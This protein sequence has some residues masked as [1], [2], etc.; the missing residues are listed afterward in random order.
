MLALQLAM[1][2]SP[3]WLRA[4]AVAP[5]AATIGVERG[6]QFAVAN[7]LKRGPAEPGGVKALERLAHRRRRKTKLA[8]Y[9]ARRDIG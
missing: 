8:R 5:F 4:A 6:F 7:V 2:R 3:I 9:L 1:D